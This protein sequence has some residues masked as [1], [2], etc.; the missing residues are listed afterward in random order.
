MQNNASSPISFLEKTA[1]AQTLLYL[2]FNQQGVNRTDIANNVKAAS[3]TIDSTLDFLKQNQ[4]I[5]E[6]NLKSFPPQ[7]IFTL[8]ELGL[9]VAQPLAVIADAMTPQDSAHTAKP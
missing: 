4:L 5:N 9:K 7:R 2:F 3:N 1:V 6:K 8:T